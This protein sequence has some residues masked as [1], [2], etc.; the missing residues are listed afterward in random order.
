MISFLVGCPAPSVGYWYLV[1]QDVLMVSSRVK[2]FLTLKVETTTLFRNVMHQL[3][4]DMASHSR[5]TDFCYV[6]FDLW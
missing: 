2:D 6:L 1:F 5:R 3:P 4:S